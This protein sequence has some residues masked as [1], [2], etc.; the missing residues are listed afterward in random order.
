MKKIKHPFLTVNSGK[1][2]AFGGNQA[3]FSREFL[4]KYGC[5]IIGAADVLLCLQE[6][7]RIEKTEFLKFS[8]HLWKYY[9]PVMP[10]YGM[11]GLT[12]MFGMNRYFGKQKL[13]YRCFWCFSKKKL[14][15]RMDTMLEQG[16]PVILS[17]GPNL[18]KLW[19]N[20]KLTFYRKTEKGNYV[21]A[22]KTKAHYVVVTARDHQWI[23]I[24]SWGEKY[25]ISLNEYH[26]YVK[27]YSSYIVSN[28]IC[29]QKRKGIK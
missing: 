23:E 21:P 10:K 2:T 7:E 24:S 26:M 27:Q 15:S 16:I 17:I 29:I 20:E 5:G 28:I 25:Y 8:E 14:F 11:N 1:E 12:L 13:P 3:W 18:P 4:K 22:V 19:G 6:N 9:L